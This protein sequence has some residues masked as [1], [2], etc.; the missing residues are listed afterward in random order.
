MKIKNYICLA[1]IAALLTPTSS[2]LAL[3]NNKT[4]LT[5]EQKAVIQSFEKSTINKDNPLYNS[6]DSKTV[7]TSAQ[8]V[9]YNFKRGGALAWSKDWID[10]SYSSGTVTRSEAWQE[11]G[12]IFP[13]IVRATGITKMSSSTSRNHEYKAS[14]TIGAG[15]VSPWGDVTVYESDYTDYLNANGYGNFSVY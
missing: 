10:W 3:S 11:A 9:R 14:K 2:V 1:C 5:S 13:N 7:T 4:N 6:K 15:V 12:Y 8:S